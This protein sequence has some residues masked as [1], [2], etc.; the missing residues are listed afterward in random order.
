MRRGFF[1]LRIGSVKQEGWL[2]GGRLSIG[3]GGRGERD[4]SA[5][6][7]TGALAEGRWC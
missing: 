6:G 5:V 2:V 3:C 7:E 4:Y 1:I